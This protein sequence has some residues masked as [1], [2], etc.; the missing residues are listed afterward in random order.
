MDND[1][2]IK[3]MKQETVPPPQ[4]LV[5]LAK[6]AKMGKSAR[7]VKRHIIFILTSLNERAEQFR[8]NDQQ[9]KV[10]LTDYDKPKSMKP[11]EFISRVAKMGQSK[12][13]VKRYGIFIPQDLNATVREIGDRLLKVTLTEF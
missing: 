13:G 10:I 5:F 1:Y 7:G 4:S 9:I 3:Q 2:I 11:V 12:K 8:N 6:T